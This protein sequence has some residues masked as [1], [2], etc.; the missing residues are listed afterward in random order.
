M[1]VTVWKPIFFR[2]HWESAISRCRKLGMRVTVWKL[3]DLPGK[4]QLVVESAVRNAGD[5]LETAVAAFI[6]F[7]GSPSAVR[8]AG[9]R[10]ETAVAA[11]AASTKMKRSAVRNAGDRLETTAAP[12]PTR[13]IHVGS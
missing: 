9:D 13:P 4:G 6:T 12:A 1:R 7:L 3:D 8:N 11:A 2:E 5:R 10:L